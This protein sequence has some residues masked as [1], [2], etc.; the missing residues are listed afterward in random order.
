MAFNLNI[1]K[2]VQCCRISINKSEKLI[3]ADIFN[4]QFNKTKKN[5][6]KFGENVLQWFYLKKNQLHY[7]QNCTVNFRKSSLFEVAYVMQQSP[8]FVQ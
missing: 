4:K 8:R 7:C 6:T 5:K 1:P 3:K 2:I